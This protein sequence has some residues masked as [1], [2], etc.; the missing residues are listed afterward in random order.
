MIR[1]VEP[2]SEVC[3]ACVES[4]DTWP[5][6]RMCLTCGY[7]GCCEDAKNQHALKHYEETDHPLMR[8]YRERGMNWMWCYPDE[9]LLDPP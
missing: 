4:G 8:A 7:V 2:S 1:A 6:L 5:A 9:A 3:D